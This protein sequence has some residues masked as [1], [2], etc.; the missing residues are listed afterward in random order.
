MKKN[1][2]FFCHMCYN[3]CKTEKIKKLGKYNTIGKNT[4]IG[5]LG[6]GGGILYDYDMMRICFLNF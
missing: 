6:V 2:D 4:Q 3:T 1:L 5:R